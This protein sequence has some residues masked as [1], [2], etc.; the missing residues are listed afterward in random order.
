MVWKGR[1]IT[2]IN[3][4]AIGPG[5]AILRQTIQTVALLE[6]FADGTIGIRHVDLANPDVSYN[7]TVDL[8]AG[9][10]AAVKQFSEAIV[11][12]RIQE[13]LAHEFL[14]RLDMKWN[15]KPDPSGSPTV[16]GRC[17]AWRETHSEAQSFRQAR[18]RVDGI[19]WRKG[20]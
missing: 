6:F 11:T 19:N 2:L 16:G 15:G 9:F 18:R 14:M 1:G 20:R 17:C 5:S 8:S 12:S 13:R 3:P 4:G 10:S 7:H